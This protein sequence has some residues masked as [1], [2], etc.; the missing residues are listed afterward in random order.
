[1]LRVGGE[2]LEEVVKGGV[3]EGVGG[4]EGEGRV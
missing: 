3:E 1:M 2:E 4:E